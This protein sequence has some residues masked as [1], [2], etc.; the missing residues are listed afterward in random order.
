MEHPQG[1]DPSDPPH[2]QQAAP[3]WRPQG[4]HEEAH[5][6]Q[7]MMMAGAERSLWRVPMHCKSGDRILPEGFTEEL[8]QVLLAS[9][10]VGSALTLDA[11]MLHST[12]WSEPAGFRNVSDGSVTRERGLV[13]QKAIEEL[14]VGARL[15]TDTVQKCWKV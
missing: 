5:S 6:D 9:F 10:V 2:M 1:S 11:S 7:L 14:P 13:E 12:L 8:L 3:Q 4:E 15:A